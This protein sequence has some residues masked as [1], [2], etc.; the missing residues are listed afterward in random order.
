VTIEGESWGDVIAQMEAFVGRPEPA[1]PPVVEQ[2][3]QLLTKP[4]AA[5][6]DEPPHVAETF[7]PFATPSEFWAVGQC[8][9][10]LRPW[11]DGKFG[12]FCSAKDESGPK[13]YCTLR[14]G[15]IWNG[16]NIPLLVPA[17]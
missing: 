7:A 14:P 15:D 5:V 13:G 16:K 10:H 11:K 1:V 3:V 12:P 17:A 6:P 9:K 4:V 8:P 2:A